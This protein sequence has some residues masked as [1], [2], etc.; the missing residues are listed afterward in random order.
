MNY[1]CPDCTE[2]T[3]SIYCLYCSVIPGKLERNAIF[4]ICEYCKENRNIGTLF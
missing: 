2:L 3:G 4:T 1:L